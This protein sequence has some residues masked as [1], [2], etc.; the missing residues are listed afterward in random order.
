MSFSPLPRTRT[1]WDLTCFRCLL[2]IGFTLLSVQIRARI[3][4]PGPRRQLVEE[5]LWPFPVILGFVLVC[6]AVM[7]FLQRQRLLGSAAAA[8][9]ILSAIINFLP[10]LLREGIYD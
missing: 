4:L 1:E 6:C 7:A 10:I 3:A 5:M 9:G 8:V 2:A